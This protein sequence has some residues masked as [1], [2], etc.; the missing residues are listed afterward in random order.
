MT[1]FWEKCLGLPN[2][3]QQIANKHVFLY[4]SISEQIQLHA[5]VK[6]SS[7]PWKSMQIEFK[8]TKTFD[9]FTLWFYLLI[10]DSFLLFLFFFL[11]LVFLI[12]EWGKFKGL[13][14]GVLD[15]GACALKNINKF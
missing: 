5:Q 8:L 14:M 9:L 10:A 4:S 6:L 15:N 1:C 12:L 13:S 3:R 2:F 11:L 7:Y